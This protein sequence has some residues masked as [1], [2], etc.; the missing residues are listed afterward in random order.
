M[1]NPNPNTSGLRP[2]QSPG[3][4]PLNRDRLNVSL[5]PKV[6]DRVSQIAD[7]LGTSRPKVIELLVRHALG[8][9]VIDGYDKGD[10]ELILKGAPID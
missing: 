1:P 8:M 10:L 6:S 4:K 7:N 3:R 2:G 9:Y 5:D